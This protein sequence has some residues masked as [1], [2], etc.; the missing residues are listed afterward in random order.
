MLTSNTFYCCLCTLCGTNTACRPCGHSRARQQLEDICSSQQEAR[1]ALLRQHMNCLMSCTRLLHRS[2]RSAA[3][4]RAC[5]LPARTM[6]M[7][8]EVGVNAS[9]TAAGLHGPAWWR[10][11]PT[12]NSS[13]SLNTCVH[14]VLDRCTARVV[15]A[16]QQRSFLSVVQSHA[17]APGSVCLATSCV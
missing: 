9:C 8:A 4:A 7:H 10:Q 13:C 1:C 15:L 17:G 16:A 2:I 14:D 6:R 11:P 5:A 12:L 3:H